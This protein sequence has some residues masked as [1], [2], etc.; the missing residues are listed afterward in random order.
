MGLTETRLDLGAARVR[1]RTDVPALARLIDAMYAGFGHPDCDDF[2]DVTV[3]ILRVGGPR[4]WLNPQIEL[5]VD[6]QSPFEPFPADTHLPLFEWGVNFAF[7][8]RHLHGLLLHAGVVDSNGR[9]LILPAVPGSGKS[10]LTAALMQRGYRLLS[11]EFGIVDHGDG[12]LRPL[13]RPIAL[14]N[15]SI[16]VIRAMFPQARFG[17][18]FPKTRKGTVSHLIPSADSVAR[19]GL[20]ASPAIVV[21][22]QF[23]AG[24]TTRL[25]PVDKASAFSRLAVNAF[26]YE[27]LGRVAF[28]AVAALVDACEAWELVFGHLDPACALIDQLFAGT[29]PGAPPPEVGP[30]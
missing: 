23:E 28:D 7:A 22:P 8:E 29:H 15:E 18:V 1:V 20:A 17:P 26:N 19:A 5:V 9:G 11:D 13:V 6:G 3:G 16:P 4:R 21:F 30:G 25:H 12:T 10:T 2:H 27:P 14:K 24:A